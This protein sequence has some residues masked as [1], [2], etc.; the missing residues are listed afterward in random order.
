[1]P[2]NRRSLVRR[3]VLAG[4]AAAP[5]GLAGGAP[6]R[7]MALDE[8]PEAHL[9]VSPSLEDHNRVIPASS[10]V[11]PLSI[12][13]PPGHGR[14]LTEWSVSGE[15]YV[16]AIAPEGRLLRRPRDD[17]AEHA[18]FSWETSAHPGQTRPNP[19]SYLGYNAGLYGGRIVEGEPAA[20]FVIEADYDDG[21]KR[22]VELY[23]EVSSSDGAARVRPFFWQFRRDATSSRTFVTRATVVGDPFVVQTPDHADLAMFDRNRTLFQASEPDLDNGLYVLAPQ[24]RSAFLRLAGDGMAGGFSVGASPAT[25]NEAY[26]ELNDRVVGWFFSSPLGVPGAS[27]AIGAHDNSAA[28]V[29]AV[30][31][32]Q[33]DVMALVARGRGSQRGD[34]QQWQEADGTRLLSVT[35]DGRF[36]WSAPNERAAADVSV[37]ATPARYLRVLDSDGNEL[38][39][40]AFAATTARSARGSCGAAGRGRQGRCASGIWS[41]WRARWPRPRV[42]R[43][44]RPARRVRRRPPARRAPRAP[45]SAR[46]SSPRRAPA[47]RSP[48]RPCARPPRGPRRRPPCSGRRRSCG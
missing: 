40:P 18:P 4:A 46:G 12:S 32:S 17:V 25:P 39:V 36:R 44:R 7:A 16:T 35:R 2:L 26:V 24:N 10:S 48:R 45:R 33:I 3:A 6:S 42:S 14:N 19:V 27:F 43:V 29:F 8:V 21:E 30:G 13:A 34:L 28:G 47:P 20:V 9:V 31:D 11:L 23:A 41:G 15:G 37:G 1:M 5:I 22:A 38:L